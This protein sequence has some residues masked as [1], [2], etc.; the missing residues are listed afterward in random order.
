L[1]RPRLYQGCSAIEE[2]EEEE[3]E[4]EA[5]DLHGITVQQHTDSALRRRSL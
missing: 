1:N 3:E 5:E 2:E 4:E